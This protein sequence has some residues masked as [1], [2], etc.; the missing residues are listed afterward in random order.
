MKLRK[1]TSAKSHRQNQD[2]DSSLFFFLNVLLF[3]PEAAE[4]GS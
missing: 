4:E 3:H 1:M 2:S